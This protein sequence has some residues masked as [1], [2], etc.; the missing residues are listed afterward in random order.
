MLS[1]SPFSQLAARSDRLHGRLNIW[2][3]QRLTGDDPGGTWDHLRCRQ[4]L[5][6]DQTTGHGVADLQRDRGLLNGQPGNPFLVVRQPMIVTQIATLCARQVL[7]VPVRYP[8]R[9]SVAAVV[10]SVQTFDNS[11]TS[12]Y[13]RVCHAT[14]L[15]GLRPFHPQFRVHATL[16]VHHQHVLGSILV[17][18]DDDFM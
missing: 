17:V 5:L 18:G 16:P 10:S 1:G 15:A 12:D 14:V 4:G 3:R 2:Q 9:F 7:P 11:R 8:S 6:T 13:V